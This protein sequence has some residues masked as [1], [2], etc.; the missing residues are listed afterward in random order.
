MNMQDNL[1]KF[2]SNF[3]FSY[4]EEELNT[5]AII[6]DKIIKILYGN[7]NLSVLEKSDINYLKDQKLVEEIVGN[8]IIVYIG[9]V[10][11]G[12]VLKDDAKTKLYKMLED[13][14]INLRKINEKYQ[15]ARMCNK[16]LQNETNVNDLDEKDIT[17]LVNMII[18]SN[19]NEKEKEDLLVNVSLS[20][21]HETK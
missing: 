4:S 2:V 18:N 16:L 3:Q 7:E 9:Y 6:F 13:I 5:L 8:L 19:T 12:A 20:I 1:K 17:T 10:K 15:Q 14:V 11:S 21:H